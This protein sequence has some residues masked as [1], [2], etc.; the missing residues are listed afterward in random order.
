MPKD[1]SYVHFERTAD[2]K[3]G[4]V[5]LLAS[6]TKITGKYFVIKYRTDHMKSGQIW[7]NTKENGH[8]GGTAAFSQGY[9]TNGQWQVL[10]IDLVEALDEG[11]FLPNSA[12]KYPISHLRWDIW[13]VKGTEDRH[14]DIAYIGIAD[15][16]AELEAIQN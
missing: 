8:S 7:V 11:K 4:Y 12:G 5:M 15:N 6:N 16:E 13:D 14:I 3:D 9:K 2:T 1:G 10:V